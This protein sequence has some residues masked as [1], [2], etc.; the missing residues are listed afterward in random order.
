MRREVSNPSDYATIEYK[1]MLAACLAVCI[2]GNGKYGIVDDEGDQ[3]MPIFLFGGHDEW[4]T[5]KF[6]MD[7][8]TA[9]AQTDKEKIAA[10]LESMQ[11]RGERSSMNDFCGRAHEMAKALRAA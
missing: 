7:F 5:S 3:G 1:D 10:A 8:E 9:F 4:F 6:G 2:V 11:L